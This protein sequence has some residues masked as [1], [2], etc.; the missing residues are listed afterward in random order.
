MCQN[1]IIVM[2]SKLPKIWFVIYNIH[3]IS[4][5]V[6]FSRKFRLVMSSLTCMTCQVR[7]SDA[8]LHR[9]HFKGEKREAQISFNATLNTNN[10][11]LFDPRRLAPIQSEEESCPASDRLLWIVRRAKNCSWGRGESCREVRQGA[12]RLLRGMREELQESQGLWKPY[13]FQE[14][15][16]NDP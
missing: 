13:C 1:H 8:D 16:R 14:T 11:N 10:T 9:S 4:R 12:L 5:I 3:I 15:S 2:K 6:Y 7:F